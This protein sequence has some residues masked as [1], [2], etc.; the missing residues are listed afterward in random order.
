MPP[1][2]PAPIPETLLDAIFETI[3]IM[4]GSHRP[5]TH[6]DKKGKVHSVNAFIG[7]GDPITRAQVADLLFRWVKTGDIEVLVSSSERTLS[8]IP[9]PYALSTP[10][11]SFGSAVSPLAASAAPSPAASAASSPA[12][13]A[14]PGERSEPPAASAAPVARSQQA[15]LPPVARSRRPQG[16][17]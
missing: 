9:G 17:Q 6:T 15:A 16:A 8:L 14:A 5:S 11:A 12:A 1:P 3:E 10:A 7:K 13:S 2:T 4:P